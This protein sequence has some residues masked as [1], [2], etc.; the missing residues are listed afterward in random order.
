MIAGRPQLGVFAK[1]KAMQKLL[2][3]LDANYRPVI[4]SRI[5]KWKGHW[6]GAV[7]ITF[8]SISFRTCCGSIFHTCIGASFIYLSSQEKKK[9]A[10]APA[11]L[12]RR[13]VSCC[14]LPP[15]I[16]LLLASSRV[17]RW[18]GGH[19]LNQK[20]QSLGFNAS[21]L[22]WSWICQTAGGGSRSFGDGD[23]NLTIRNCC[24]WHAGSKWR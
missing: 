16:E 11:N 21:S 24:P 18:F 12:T 13:S 9:M 8:L 1:A 19:V 4:S 17:C 15:P 2:G 23:G 20:N 5:A 22:L 3:Y 6:K 7:R 14:R 10:L